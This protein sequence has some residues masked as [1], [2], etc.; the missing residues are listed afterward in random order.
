MKNIDLNT[1]VGFGREWS[2]FDQNGLSEEDKSKIF[3]DYFHIFPWDKLSPNAIG[4][5][6]GCGS[7][8]WAQV[9]AP[10]VGHLH[11]IDASQEALQVAKNNVSPLG[12]CSFHHAS[13]GDLP[14]S[15]NSLDFAYSLGVLHHV[16]ETVEGISSIAKKLKQGSPFLVYLYYAF[17]NQPI[18]FRMM[19]RV[20]D[21]I[22]RFISRLPYILRLVLSQLIAILIYFPLARAARLLDLLKVMPRSWPL[23]YYRDKSFYVMRTDALDRFGTRLEQR[24]SKQ[25]IE[26]ML[27]KSGFKDI[28][29]SDE[30]PYW[31]AVGIKDKV[32]AD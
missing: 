19:W 28:Y 12:N 32:C 5:D 21:I 27:K 20:S 4:A 29:F 30:Q 31:C 17:D 16:P 9:V 24:F 6:I 22:R 7:G 8:R 14:F 25:K 1:V 11:L 2:S 23:G 18:W 15:D 13:V 26:L 3:D 10:R